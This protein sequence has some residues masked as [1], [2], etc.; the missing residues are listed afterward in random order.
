MTDIVERKSITVPRG[1]ASEDSSRLTEANLASA[2]RLR[3][4]IDSLLL[5][6]TR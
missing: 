5:S 6:S 4:L 2:M 1:P 3:S